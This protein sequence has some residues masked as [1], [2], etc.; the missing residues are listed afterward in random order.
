MPISINLVCSV[1]TRLKASVLSAITLLIVGCAGNGGFPPP[2]QS[3]ETVP[4]P[5][6][7]SEISQKWLDEECGNIGS[8]N[9]RMKCPEVLAAK[10]PPLDLAHREL[11]GRYYNPR[12]YLQCMQ[13]ASN[14]SNVHCLQ[15]RLRRIEHPEY[16]PYPDAPPVKWPEP[17]NPPTYREGMSKQEY[18]QALC[19]KEAGWFIYRPVENVDGIYEVRPRFR[20]ESGPLQDP[21]AIED[22]WGVTLNGWVSSHMQVK[23]IQPYIGQYALFESRRY[24]GRGWAEPLYL[25]ERLLPSE[26]SKS[27]YFQYFRDENLKPR[28]IYPSPGDGKRQATGVPYIVNLRPISQPTA[29]YGY[30]W[31]GITR[32]HALDQYIQ[33][34]ELIILDL[35][36]NEILGVRRAFMSAV[37]ER[38]SWLNSYACPNMRDK[39]DAKFIQ[40]VLKPRPENADY[41]FKSPIG[42]K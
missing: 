30:T 14:G 32:P 40:A 29:R 9:M 17:H 28:D 8:F 22:P 18:F 34:G 6:F 41:Q 37:G 25:S 42:P 27:G 12:K 7:V 3:I 5:S 24:Y 2:E 19:E 10:L 33:G 31:R 36:T 39:M 11:F 21:Y 4:M 23:M 15:Y 20:E 35:K 16:W 1:V 13:E 38:F 26:R